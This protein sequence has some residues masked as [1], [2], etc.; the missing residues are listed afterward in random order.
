MFNNLTIIIHYDVLR[1]G[2]KLSERT[3]D[4]V[5]GVVDIDSSYFHDSPWLSGSLGELRPT[6]FVSNLA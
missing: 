4:G 5:A 2:V 3:C 1:G 6:F